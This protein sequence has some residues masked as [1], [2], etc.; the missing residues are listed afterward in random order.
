MTSK[1]R[2]TTGEFIAKARAVWGEEYDYSRTVYRGPGQPVVIICR[3]HG[4][5]EQ[6]PYN[7][8]DGHRCHQ[9]KVDRMRMSQAEF[10]TRARVLFP[11]YDYARVAYRLAAVKV[12]MICPVHGAFER[13]PSEVLEGRGCP[14]CCRKARPKRGPQFKWRPV[15]IEALRE[16][17]RERRMGERMVKSTLRV[18]PGDFSSL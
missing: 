16:C 14:K 15:E 4:P 3:V 9:C 5:F 1:L 7:H 12:E 10:V 11:D 6:W 2:Q 8:L 18:V 17:L 13:R